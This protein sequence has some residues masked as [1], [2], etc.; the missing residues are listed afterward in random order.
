MWVEELTLENIK[1]FEKCTLKFS[2][3]TQERPRWITLLSENGSGKT[4]I[5]QALALL[6]AGPESASQLSP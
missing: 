2:T 6:L 1:C 4:T 5:L 3:K